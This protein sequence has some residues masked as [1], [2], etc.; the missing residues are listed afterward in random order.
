MGRRTN[1]FWV[2]RP[3]IKTSGSLK[4]ASMHQT[5][6]SVGVDKSFKFGLKLFW[7]GLKLFRFGL[8]LF[9]FGLDIFRFGLKF[10]WFGFKLFL[11]WIEASQVWNEAFSFMFGLNL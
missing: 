4:L 3:T 7:F 2:F 1:K 10:V 9:R 6:D 11:V 5:C 8:K